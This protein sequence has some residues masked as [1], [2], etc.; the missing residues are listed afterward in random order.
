MPASS[1]RSAGAAE[2][3][4]V[5]ERDGLAHAL[6]GRAERTRQ[7]LEDDVVRDGRGDLAGR[8]PADA[9]DHAEDAALRVDERHV[10]VVGP[11]A[12]GIGPVRAACSAGMARSRVSVTIED[13]RETD[14]PGEG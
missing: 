12:A 2:D 11:D 1:R 5:G 4:V 14:E 6:R 13:P 7:P 3:L 10:F 9:V 8:L